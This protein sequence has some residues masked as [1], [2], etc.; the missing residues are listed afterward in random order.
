MILSSIWAHIFSKH[1]SI[2]VP[3][4]FFFCQTV[5][6]SSGSEACSRT[7]P[8]NDS[9]CA[10]MHASAEGLQRPFASCIQFAHRGA[11][12]FD[13]CRAGLNTSR[14]TAVQLRSQVG[15]NALNR[16]E[17]GAVHRVVLQDMKIVGGQACDRVFRP[18]TPLVVLD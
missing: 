15:P 4:P 14:R 9:I 7:L 12:A 16:I 1:F 5:P 17:I 6:V 13:E 3:I 2:C 8:V 11:E 10:L 18:Q